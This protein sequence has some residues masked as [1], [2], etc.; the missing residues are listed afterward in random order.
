LFR[1]DQGKYKEA[2]PLFVRALA[3]REKALGAE[4]PDVATVLGN[5]SSLLRAT[6]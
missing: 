5:Y 4:H 2:E 3:I 1:C 6:E